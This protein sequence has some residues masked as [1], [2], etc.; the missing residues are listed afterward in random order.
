MQIGADELDARIREILH[1]EVMAIIWDQIPELFRSI[2][3]GI[4]GFFD[5]R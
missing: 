3:N 4:M 2:K 1:G 5:D